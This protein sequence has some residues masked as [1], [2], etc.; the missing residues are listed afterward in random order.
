MT[1]GL[2][3]RCQFNI[4]NNN[5]S[6]SAQNFLQLQ[7]S[8]MDTFFCLFNV[9]DKFNE[10]L[11]RQIETVMTAFESG[12]TLIDSVLL[13]DIPFAYF[14]KVVSIEQ[15]KKIFFAMFFAFKFLIPCIF[16]P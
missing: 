1:K 6:Q 5:K 7:I 14:Y 4:S 12:P 9:S 2:Q 11:T 8:C 10:F 13:S 16:L 15:G 3:P